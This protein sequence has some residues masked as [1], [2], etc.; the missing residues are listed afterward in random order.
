M[1]NGLVAR[2][3]TGTWS[4]ARTLK[5]SS[6]VYKFISPAVFYDAIFSSLLHTLLFFQS[7]WKL[8]SRCLGKSKR[9]NKLCFATLTSVLLLRNKLLCRRHKEQLLELCFPAFLF[10]KKWLSRH[11][12][13]S[14]YKAHL[15]CNLFWFWLSWDV[16]LQT[17]IFLFSVICELKSG[18]N[19]SGTCPMEAKAIYFS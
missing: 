14:F 18:F 7:C 16:N 3:Q 5:K 9:I 1:K 11:V 17:Y 6:G 15:H 2:R 13:V 8:F 4:Q 19:K 10:G 12:H